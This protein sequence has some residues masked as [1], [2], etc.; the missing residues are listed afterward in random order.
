MKMIYMKPNAFDYETQV[1]EMPTLWFKNFSF[2]INHDYNTS[3]KSSF[4][5]IFFPF[6]FS[7]DSP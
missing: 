2:F 4:E 7:S 5:Q 6:L 1:Q 3:T